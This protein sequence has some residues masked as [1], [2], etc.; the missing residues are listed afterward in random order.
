MRMFRQL[1]AQKVDLAPFT[2]IIYD[3]E[4]IFAERAIV[5]RHVLGAPFAA[6]EA[7]RRIDE[8]LD[9]A[10]NAHIVLAVNEQNAAMFKGAGH[11]DARVLR[12]AVTL[13]SS[14]EPFERREGFLFVGPTRGDRQPNSD[15]VVWFVD[16]VLPRL[17]AVLRR[18]ASL[19]LAGMTG[20]A[21]VT[22][23]AIA[24]LKLLGAVPDLTERYS[25]TR[26][27]VAPTRFAAGIPLKVYDA[28]AHGV[29]AVITPLLASHLG[30]SDNHEALVAQTP[31]EFANACARL[32]EDAVLWER[33][34]TNAM[35]RVAQ[36]CNAQLFDRTVAD[37]VAGI[38]MRRQ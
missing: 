20:A 28:A 36:D 22:T 25:S 7:K 30:W 26:V 18:D 2:T 27:F 37:L 1:T 38:T 6:E 16:Q 5:K 12:Y 11:R 4:A 9:L 33:I 34:R 24:G 29:P 10:S 8:E 21:S 35:A 23:R 3:A 14:P 17:R 32:H 19:L 31:A 15:A 13:R